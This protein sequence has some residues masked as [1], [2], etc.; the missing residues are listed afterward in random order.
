ERAPTH[1]GGEQAV[2]QALAATPA[3]PPLV[4]GLREVVAHPLAR[5]LPSR[6]L[7]ALARLALEA[8]V[9]VTRE[10]VGVLERDAEDQARD[11]DR[12]PHREVPDQ[13]ELALRDLLVEEALH[14][15]ARPSLEPARRRGQEGRREEP[16][17]LGV[18]RR[19]EAREGGPG[20]REALAEEELE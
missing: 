2:D 10:Q 14:E 3:A 11:P 7:A 17:Q 6:R 18:A 4:H 1:L 19:V 15:R 8:P 13:V 9:D 5:G 12:E 16:S 20:I